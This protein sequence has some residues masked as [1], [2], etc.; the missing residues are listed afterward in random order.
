MNNII[1]FIKTFVLLILLNIFQV[2][3]DSD[4]LFLRNIVSILII[5]HIVEIIYYSGY[6]SNSRY[7]YWIATFPLVMYAAIIYLS[8]NIY[9]SHHIEIVIHEYFILFMGLI[10]DHDLVSAY[11]SIFL[12]MMSTVYIFNLLYISFNS[13]MVIYLFAIWLIHILLMIIVN[14]PLKN[15]IYDILDICLSSIPAII[16]AVIIYNKHHSLYQRHYNI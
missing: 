8:H 9:F 1:M 7:I 2:P 5:V 13:Y 14:S 6:L 15:R 16:I 3:L 11:F 4:N 12:A 10:S